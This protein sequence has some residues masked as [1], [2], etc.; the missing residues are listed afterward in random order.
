VKSIKDT[1]I[2]KSANINHVGD[3]QCED[4]GSKVPIYE[5]QG[6]QISICMTCKNSELSKRETKN[7]EPPKLRELKKRIKQIEYIPPDI[8]DATFE[9]YNPKSPT[10]KE[11]LDMA[12]GFIQDKFQSIVF[13]GSPGIGKSHLF[14]CVAREV[15]K[16]KV[17]YEENG[18]TYDV[19]QSV[20]FAKVPELLKL[21]QSTFDN[22]K[23]HL[24]E[25]QLLKV[26]NDVDVLILDEIGG[27]RSKSD[28]NQ[29][30][31]WSGDILYQ[32]VDHRQSKRNLYNTNYSSKELRLKY[33]QTQANRI[34][35]RMM[36]Q[37]T[38]LQIEG[39]DHRMGGF[40]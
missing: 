21:I 14:R 18:R 32:I 27:E 11:A 34:L 10:Q 37:A 31:T 39:P 38:T 20:L 22:P 15:A 3:R 6:E 13:Q 24:K 40:K 5:R 19:H 28:P 12:H 30:E 26:V 33:G 17:K 4:C 23:G 2:L 25:H 1:N 8:Q 16:K 9:G 7:Y 29:F 35:S 36:N